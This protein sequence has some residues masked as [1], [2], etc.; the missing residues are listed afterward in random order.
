LKNRIGLTPIGESLRVTVLRDGK[1]RDV[2]VRIGTT[3]QSSLAGG[4]LI[5]RLRG[6]EFRNTESGDPYYGN[7]EG[8]YVASVEQGSPAWRNGIREGDL[9]LAVNR[10]RIRDVDQLSE[11]LQ[12]SG[13]TVA[14]DVLRGNARLFIV[15]Q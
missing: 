9:V 12:R 4:G 7:V 15:L 5:P 6:A 13:P 1:S 11:V 8:A 10:L 14:L 3:G 2:D